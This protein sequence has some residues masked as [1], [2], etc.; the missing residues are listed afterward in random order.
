MT[1]PNLEVAAVR[2]PTTLN[3]LGPLATH[4]VGAERDVAIVHDE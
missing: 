4:A 3:C 1:L 2:G